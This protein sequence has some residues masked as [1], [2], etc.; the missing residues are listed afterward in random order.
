M[1]DYDLR[2]MMPD[3]ITVE[4]PTGKNAY[5]RMIYDD[6]VAYQARIEQ[7]TTLIRDQD[8]R[9]R[10]S[11]VQIYLAT[12]VLLPLSARITLPD[13]STPSIM[14]IEQVRD[15]NGAYATKVST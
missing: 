4:L 9:E 10:V 11:N 14:A 7:R 8:G 6:P 5:S 12:E 1:I 15:E 3:E 13:G 2:L